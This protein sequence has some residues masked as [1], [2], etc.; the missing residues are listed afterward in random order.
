MDYIFAGAQ[1][2]LV[3]PCGQAGLDDNILSAL[4]TAELQI[5]AASAASTTAGVLWR[6]SGDGAAALQAIHAAETSLA[7]AISN[8][9]TAQLLVDLDTWLDLPMCLSPEFEKYL[10]KT[11]RD[12]GEGDISTP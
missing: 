4:D 6:E 12:A 3:S 2:T 5:S 10:G 8:L 11:L 7:R 9:E 1:Y